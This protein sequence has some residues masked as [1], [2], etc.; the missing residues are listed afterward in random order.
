MELSD[1]ID[2][3]L[4]KAFESKESK[5][6]RSDLARYGATIVLPLL[7]AIEPKIKQRSD[8]VYFPTL[9]FGEQRTAIET[10]SEKNVLAVFDNAVE[11][12]REIG[13]KAETPLITALADNSLCVRTEAA[14]LV[15]MA[16]V[17]S[18]VSV[19]V[20]KRLAIDGKEPLVVRLAAGL[21][22]MNSE[23]T[24]QE[25]W[26]EISR[27]LKSW[28]DKTYPFW[29]ADAKKQGKDAQGF[30][31]MMV[32]AMI[33]HLLVAEMTRKVG[34]TFCSQC[35][36][37]SPEEAK[38]CMKCGKQ[39]IRQTEATASARL[40]TNSS[41]GESLRVGGQGPE[42]SEEDDRL[43]AEIGKYLTQTG[44]Y[45]GPWPEEKRER[46]RLASLGTPIVMPTI[47]IALSK[48]RTF[49]QSVDHFIAGPVSQQGIQLVF[50]RSVDLIS[51][52]VESLDREKQS[53]ARLAVSKSLIE[54]LE[55]G[56][57][58]VRALTA[59]YCGL[60]VVNQDAIKAHLLHIFMT[61]N[62]ALV[63]SAVAV[64]LENLEN[65]EGTKMQSR[66]VLAN[67]AK[68]VAPD[69]AEEV[70]Q[71]GAKKGGDDAI[72]EVYKGIAIQYLIGL[73][74]KQ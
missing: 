56:E 37:E 6:L 5:A 35:G 20:L 65:I 46:S 53:G 52:V 13:S 43:A 59:L 14:V 48:M 3:Y 72:A 9:K 19:P 29:E 10:T 11:L 47:R 8:L 39:Q 33:P 36:A 40:M 62:N 42:R 55:D 66:L 25:T 64:P 4:G 16:A 18:N 32:T 57:P 41:S 44:P 22:L 49:G 45:F 69:W 1:R 24:D 73:I 68:M 21:S 26:D 71:L 23:H 30:I 31:S 54:G 38:F 50:Q 34:K 12:V 74:A 60:S 70:K 61:D 28:A 7:Q 63:K 15:G 67:L 2:D 58:A 51:E 27:F 17:R